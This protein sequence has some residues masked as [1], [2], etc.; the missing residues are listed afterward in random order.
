MCQG[1]LSIQSGASAL[2]KSPCVVL[3]FRPREDQAACC[4]MEHPEG[5]SL[6]AEKK[7]VQIAVPPKTCH[8]LHFQKAMYLGGCCCQDFTLM[9]LNRSCLA[10]G[11]SHSQSSGFPQGKTRGAEASAEGMVRPRQ[12]RAQFY[13]GN[14]Q[15]QSVTGRQSHLF[16]K[17]GTVPSHPTLSTLWSPEQ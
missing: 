1:V 13:A 16:W 3:Q 5:A 2:C 11:L 15:A 17:A 4:H 12:G 7:S 8:Y 10:H 9:Q 14:F 6:R